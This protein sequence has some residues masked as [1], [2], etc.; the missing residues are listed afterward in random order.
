MVM[1]NPLNLTL[2]LE[3]A[4]G[5]TSKRTVDLHPVN[6]GGLRNHLESGDLFEDAIVGGS[7]EDDHVLG[8]LRS[9][10]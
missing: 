8:L 5:N 3:V 2:P 7:V 4:N 6:E 1:N 9:E 10:R